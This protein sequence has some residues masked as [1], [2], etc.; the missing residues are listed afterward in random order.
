MANTLA[1]PSWTLKE[2]ARGYVNEIV[3]V[4]NMDRTYDDSYIVAGAKVGNTVKARMP[5]R[6]MVT[7]GSAYQ[8]QSLY[9]PTVPITLTTQLNVAFGYSSHEATTEV[10]RVRERYVQPG[11]EALANAV[12]IFA[13]DQV[14]RDI[15]NAIG[16]PGKDITDTFSYLDA[17]LKLTYGA[18]GEGRR[19]AVLDPRQMALIANASTTLFNPSAKI[20]EAF[21]KGMFGRDT[22]GIGKW[23]QDVNR[24][25][26][27]TGTFTASTPLVNGASQTGSS[28]IT[29]GWASGASD[30]HKGDIFTIAGVNSVNPQG[31]QDTGQLQQFTVTADISDTTGSMTIGIRP[32]IITSG[33]LQTV[34]NSPADDA[35]ITV[36]GATSA[37]AGTL[38]AVTSPQGLIFTSDAF[39]LVT[40]DLEKPNAG[41]DM[42][43]VQSK[44]WGV[45]VRFV[46][47]Y[48]ILT[49]ENASRLDMLVGAATL[50][51]RCAV[52]A[53]GK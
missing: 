40:A 12:D 42:N 27:T 36:L 26:H 33:Q 21:E 44:K 47:Q 2:T 23:F 6:F 45:A 49:D 51:D 50:Q 48:N 14:Y 15:Y 3:F 38:S 17:G 13:F 35:V 31:N 29:D 11:A 10:E 41:A 1:T 32:S 9:E 30:L 46:E 16:E 37:T 19:V 52:R 53:F 39:A 7:K 20:S 18:V 34:T 5:Q 24:P 8:P 4:K 25:I 28:L 43:R 22:L